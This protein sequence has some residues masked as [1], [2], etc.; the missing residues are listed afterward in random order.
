MIDS[1]VHHGAGSHS[2]GDHSAL[3]TDL[4]IPDPL[5]ILAGHLPHGDY[6]AVSLEKARFAPPAL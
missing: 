3:N 1:G 5:S 6:G 4:G 2:Q